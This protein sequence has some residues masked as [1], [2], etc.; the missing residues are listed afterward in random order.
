MKNFLL[1]I[2]LLEVM[3]VS[4]QKYVLLDKNLIQPVHFSNTVTLT[5]KV[6][7]F[8]PVE[9]KNIK[10][11]VNALEEI[12][13]KLSLKDSK[14]EAKQY[15]MGCITFTGLTVSLIK[16]DRLDYVL[17]SNCDNVKIT[18]HLSDAKISNANNAYFIKTWIKYIK[19]ALK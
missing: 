18:M 14:T 6:N 9:K 17:N 2:F 8:F 3:N 1:V 16:E 4:A 10:Q 12:N 15:Q 19:N 11:F 5:D 13:Q 7:G